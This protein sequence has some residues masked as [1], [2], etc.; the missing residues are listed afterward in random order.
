MKKKARE[1][2]D[3]IKTM[4]GCEAMYSAA[5]GMIQL[6][7]ASQERIWNAIRTLRHTGE[8]KFDNCERRLDGE[9]VAVF[10]RT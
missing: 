1:M 4:T 5:L 8:L 10:Y 9:Y 3:R 7:D 2:V 6:H